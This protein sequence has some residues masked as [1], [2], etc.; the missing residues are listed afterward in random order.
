MLIPTV[1]CLDKRCEGEI[2]RIDLTLFFLSQ[3]L[4]FL[5][6]DK[7][8][9]VLGNLRSRKARFLKGYIESVN[10]RLAVCRIMA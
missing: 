1:F 9:L 6:G 8:S 5:N 4:I 10:Q 7:Q 2:A 3:H